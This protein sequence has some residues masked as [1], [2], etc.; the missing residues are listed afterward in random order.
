M[1]SPHELKGLQVQLDKAKADVAVFKSEMAILQQKERQAQVAVRT[2]QERIAIVQQSNAEPIVSEHALLRWM[3]RVEGAN[4][5]KII[6][7][8]LDEKT[9]SSIKFAKNGRIVKNGITLI[10]RNST[11]VTVE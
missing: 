2:L 11:I 10:F 4:L 7:E 5:D 8:I 3:E 1:T 9:K 6:N